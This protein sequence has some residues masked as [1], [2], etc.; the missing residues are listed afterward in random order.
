[1]IILVILVALAVVFKDK[2]KIWIYKI[3][4]GFKENKN[5]GSNIP[6]PYSS[7]KPMPPRPMMPNRPFPNYPGRP[8]PPQNPPMRR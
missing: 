2:L 1:L 7:E 3:K 8:F 4:S 5:K 6:G